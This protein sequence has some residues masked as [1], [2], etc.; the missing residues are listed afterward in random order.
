MCFCMYYNKYRVSQNDV[1]DFNEFL[2]KFDTTQVN[3]ISTDEKEN[4]LS[5][6]RRITNVQYAL[7]A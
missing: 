2:H 3:T 5:F 4:S 1:P 6:F 7:H